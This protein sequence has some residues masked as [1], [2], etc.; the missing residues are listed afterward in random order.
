MRSGLWKRAR[1]ARGTALR[2]ASFTRCTAKEKTSSLQRITFPGPGGL[3]SIRPS[4]NDASGTPQSLCSRQAPLRVLPFQS[5]LLGIPPPNAAAGPS[6]RGA[7]NVTSW[8]YM[9]SSRVGP[10]GHRGL[11]VRGRGLS[12][13]QLPLLIA[14]IRETAGVL[15]HALLRVVDAYWSKLEMTSV[16]EPKPASAILGAAKLLVTSLRCV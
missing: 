3:H 2:Q 9:A 1:S 13:V 4:L 16:I 12:N 10:Q 7:Q 5:G 8:R 11:A 15:P 14:A 6:R